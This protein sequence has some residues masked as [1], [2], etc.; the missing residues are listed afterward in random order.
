MGLVVV[1]VV[2]AIPDGFARM[3]SN[4]RSPASGPVPYPARSTPTG[5]ATAQRRAIGQS[6]AAD[7]APWG[8]V[9]P[10]VRYNTIGATT[11]NFG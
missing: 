6:A 11:A 10:S 4:S 7:A 9:G 2:K 5:L 8:R 3:A 1:V